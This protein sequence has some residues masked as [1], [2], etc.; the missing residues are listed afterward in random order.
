M[1]KVPPAATLVA[2]PRSAMARASSGATRRAEVLQLRS[3]P[4][5]PL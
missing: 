1:A 5:E 3:E 4:S 2:P